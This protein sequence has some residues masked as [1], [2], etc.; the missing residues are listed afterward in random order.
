MPP[1][2]ERPRLLVLGC[3]FGG[4]SLL[5]RLPRG[6]FRT[7]L[8]TPRNYFLFTP[9]LP[10]ALT[11]SV[12]LRSILEPARR[13]LR[14]VRVIEGW[15][16][17]VDWEAR[18][19]ACAGA[20]GGERFGLAFD[21]LVIAVGAAVADYGVRGVAEHALELASVEDARAVRRGILEQF[22]RA[23]IPGL[24][25]QQVRERLTFV[26]CGGGPTG[27]EA[28]AEI[29]D[30]MGEELR[31]DYPELAP[32]G[33]VVLVEALDRIL[34]GFDAALAH[35]AQR[36]FLRGGI[37]VRTGQEV[38]AVETGLVR[39]KS[40][41]ELRCGLVLWAAGNAPVAFIRELGVPLAV[42]GRLPVDGGL[43]LP[44]HEGVFALGDCAQA[45]EP[46]L[47]ATAQ[48]A[49]Q[50]G[51]YLARALVREQEG[52]P[53]PAFRFRAQGML[54]YIGAHQAL[55]DLPQVKWSGRSAWLFWRSVYVTKLV[56]LANKIKVLFDWLKA[57]LFGRDLSRF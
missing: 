27:V 15:A 13:R 5:S 25:E 41:E 48:V 38:A 30:L 4:Y 50:Q 55:A 29:H 24:S 53:V 33:R 35:Y 47:P 32:F 57:R 17:G 10:S 51:R 54:A 11:G 28:A 40:G 23:E 14:G 31:H 7:T 3:G 44:G 42:K 56:S 39:F 45:G 12:E 19:V 16:L 2:S 36:H 52:K 34:T 22:A 6:R 26:V 18:E 20:V 46:P 8:L 37:E 49:Q 43:R 9:L 21:R 1:E